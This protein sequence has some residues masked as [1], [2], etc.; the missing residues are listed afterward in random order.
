M[1]PVWSFS[2][3]K[4]FEQCPKKYYHLKVARD[5]REE[6]TEHMRYGTEFHKAAED[7]VKGETDALD[8]RFSFAQQV[9]DEIRAMPGKN[10]AS[11]PWGSPPT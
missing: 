3:I 11:W 9:L 2:S 4:T 10:T 5:H 1:K 8:P 7:Y 6:E